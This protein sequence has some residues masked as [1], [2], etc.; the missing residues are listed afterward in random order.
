MTENKCPLCGKDVVEDEAFCRDCQEIALTSHA[1][2][3]ADEENAEDIEVVT[4]FSTVSI[5]I[6]NNAISETTFAKEV[7]EDI[8]EEESIKDAEGPSSQEESTDPIPRK[9]N[10]KSIIFLLIG[11]I[12][13]ISIGGIR[14]YMYVQNKEAEAKEAAFWNDCIDKNTP[15]AYS[16]YLVQYPEGQF[17]TMAQAKILELREQERQEWAKLR[18]STDINAFFAFLTDHPKTP[19]ER[20]IRH[21]MD[22]LSWATTSNENT[23]A[24]YLAYIENVKLGN[25]AGEY[26]SL[27]QE[28]YDYLSQM[29]TIEGEELASIKKTLTNFFKTLSS[30]KY[31]DLQKEMAPT[32]T[33]F[34]GAKN[35]TKEAIT[36]SIESDLKTRKIKS[37]A[38]TVN[39]NS[40]E[41]IRD[42]KNIYFMTLPIERQ[43]TY[44]D[45][46][47]KKETTKLIVNIE[48]NSEKEIQALYQ[49]E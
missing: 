25:F 6:E 4:N 31:K 13:L 12:L 39:M 2:Q 44:T 28:R 46:K 24:G 29:K 43:I 19:Y 9:S 41:V 49:K 42:N 23:A 21:T 26:R 20:E 14:A 11:L 10:K 22:S 30:N 45:K 33:N 3:F 47:K 32:L 27:A 17:S 7:E 38:Y 18:K 35:T 1:S 48:L 37:I 16:K 36:K 8:K 5:E 34:F 15:L 40:L